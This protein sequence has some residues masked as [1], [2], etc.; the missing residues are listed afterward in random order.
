MD[1]THLLSDDELDC[2]RKVLGRRAL[3]MFTP[4][5]SVFEHSI[6]A[7]D[8]SISLSPG[9]CVVESDWDDTRIEAIDF[10]VMH[11]SLTDH[12]KNVSITEELLGTDGKG[13]SVYRRGMSSCS[14]V[15]ISG[16]NATSTHLAEVMKIEVLECQKRG[17]E[18]Y[19]RYDHS[20]L[21]TFDN[22]RQFIEILGLKPRRSTTA[23]DLA[24]A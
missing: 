3:H 18:D 14:D 1:Y 7:R 21:L 11:V 2:L 6:L 5:V 17:I 8:F 16:G 15:Y 23:L 22:A 9:F 13:Q 12:P 4:T 19:V 10:H 24:N 20:I